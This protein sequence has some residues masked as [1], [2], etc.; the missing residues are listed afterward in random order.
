MRISAVVACAPL[1]AVALAAQ[2][3]TSGRLPGHGGQ[4]VTL[5]LLPPS[6]QTHEPLRYVLS[7][8]AYVAAFI[9]FPGAGV[10]L[11]SPTIDTPEILRRGGY[12]TD[13]LIGVSFDDDIYH[14]VLGPTYAGPAYLYLIASKHPLDVARYVHKPTRLALAIGE[15]ESRSFYTDVAFDALLNNAVALGDDTSWDSDMYML[16]P[17]DQ[18]SA[19]FADGTPING[20][21]FTSY[22]NLVCSDGTIR[23]VA[24]NYPFIGCPGQPRIR[25]ADRA[26]IQAQ[27]SA[28][29]A[30]VSPA[31]PGEVATVLPTIVG[32][33]MTDAQRHARQDATSQRVTYTTV[34]NGDQQVAAPQAEAISQAQLRVI[35]V[36]P[37]RSYEA[38]RRDRDAIHGQYSALRSE[39]LMGQ[40]RQRE[41]NGGTAGSPQLSPNPQLAPNPSLAPAPGFSRNQNQT[42]TP[43]SE[44]R[45]QREF[46]DEQHSAPREQPRAE[47]PRAEQPRAEQPRAEQPR[48]S[49]PAPAVATPRASADNSAKERG[50]IQQ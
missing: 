26:P 44:E 4:G 45:G 29:A 40:A 10:R 18:S 37:D 46:R 47:Q 19:Y 16:W 1:L 24:I 14:A 28:S 25:P 7:E 6:S 32:T 33:R 34:A 5:K 3:P 2:T 48:M 36:R 42:A 43:R 8:P 22:R 15:R 35:D 41:Q 21:A 9:V 17:S 12:N 50:R 23:V 31:S 11:L 39:Q 27:Q 13:Q 20:Q 38:V 49:Q 30:R